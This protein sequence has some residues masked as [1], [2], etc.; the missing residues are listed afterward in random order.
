MTTKD[1]GVQAGMTFFYQSWNHRKS[2][3]P[4]NR[5]YWARGIVLYPNA[6]DKELSLEKRAGHSFQLVGWDDDLEIQTVDEEG[7]PVVDE[8]GDPVME[9]GFFIFKNSWGTGSFGKDNE[10]GD[11]YGYISMRYVEEYA[12]VY[13]SDLPE[14]QLPDEVCDDG[15]DNDMD[16][17]TDCDDS[18]CSAAPECAS[19]DLETLTFTS[20]GDAVAIPD[21]DP[22][23]VTSN[24]DVARQ[25]AIH[26]ATVTV[27]VT[28][29]YRGDLRVVLYRGDDAVVLHDRSGGGQ[30][31]LKQTFD[32]TDFDGTDMSGEW[33]LKVE[34]H[35]GYDTG[36]LNGWSLEVL[37]DA[38]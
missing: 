26:S 35:A 18:D 28:H 29:T 9:Q 2:A 10:H 23:G 1:Q 16:G 4:T 7:N 17:D 27:D 13:I 8:N 33:K 11:G 5:D 30:D 21:N 14:I 12:T 20:S 3:L 15:A 31:D 6:K 32:V 38:Q 24:I 34:D 37:T 19:G 25:G 36:T 22:V